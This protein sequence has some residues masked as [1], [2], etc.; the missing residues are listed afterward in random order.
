MSAKKQQDSK[1]WG[2]GE[3]LYVPSKREYVRGKRPDV[4]CLLCAVARNED[5]VDNLVVHRE[6]NMLV[7]LNLHPYNAGHL[8]IFPERHVEE[9]RDLNRQ[10]IMALHDLQCACLDVLESLYDPRGYNIGYN[11]GLGSGGSIR[12]LHLHI[13]PRYGYEA[14][15]MD[16]LSG[17][18]VIAE[19]PR[20]TRDA[21]YEAFEH[22]RLK[23]NEDSHGD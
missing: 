22:L 4:D 13:V 9:P 14:G 2:A 20:T 8:L 12:H 7:S 23:K 11:V 6:R 5:G 18:R 3:R 19:D 16:L 21:V 15:F 10:E 17:A 1:N